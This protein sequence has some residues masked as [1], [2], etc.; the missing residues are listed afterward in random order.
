[1]FLLEQQSAYLTFIYNSIAVVK[2]Y[3]SSNAS[4]LTHMADNILWK[5]IY[6]SKD[7]LQTVCSV[8]LITST[9]FQIVAF[10]SYNFLQS[11]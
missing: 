5:I 9:E 1:M 6:T 11:P 4:L 2:R 3:N 8:H 7:E 10:E